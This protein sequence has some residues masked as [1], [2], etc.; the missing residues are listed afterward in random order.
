MSGKFLA[1]GKTS[2]VRRDE[3]SAAGP[4]MNSLLWVTAVGLAIVTIGVFSPALRCGFINWD[5]GRYVFQN[6]T[7]LG[8]LGW[9][10]LQHALCDVVFCNWAP[11]TILSYQLDVTLFGTAPWGFHLTNVLLHA[12]SVAMLFVVLARMTSAFGA[13]LLTAALFGLHPLRVESVVWIAERK[14]A[15]SVFFFMAALLAYERYCRDPSAGRFVPVCLCM[16]ASLLSKSTLVTLPVLLLV[17]DVWP[18]RRV[19]LPRDVSGPAA[20][21]RPERYPVIS[22]RQ[23]AWEKAALFALAVLFA[24][25]T[26]GTQGEAIQTEGSLPLVSARIPNA[27]HAVVWYVGKSFWPTGLRPYYRHAASELSPLAIASCGLAIVAVA[28]AVM[29]VAPR[30]PAVAAGCAWFAIALLPMLGIVAQPGFQGHADRFTYVPHVGLWLAV[31]WWARDVATS[32]RIDWRFQYA[33][34]LAVVALLGAATLRQ[35]P[36][37]RSPDTLW[38]A[39]IAQDP[40]CAMTHMKYANHLVATRRLVDAEPHYLA[41]IQNATADWPGHVCRITSL[42]N[43]ACLY[44]DLGREDRARAARDLALQLA[45]DDP[46]VVRMVGHVGEPEKTRD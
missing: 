38:P 6:P 10:G 33:V 40:T 27:V 37:W 3:P 18:L 2:A 13:S 4:R 26:I 17:L 19:R 14:D 5:D 42:A 7:V 32:R 43:L 28:L 8:G 22:W 30:R 15:L 46:A 34:G 1:H 25:I 29:R 45:P 44:K 36:M 24:A 35:I 31:V 39:M 9:A 20:A 11:L 21:A 12:A 41:A 16:L 23:A